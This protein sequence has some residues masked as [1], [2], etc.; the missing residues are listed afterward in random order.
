VPKRLRPS[1]E[2]AELIDRIR[3][4]VAERRQLEG[5]ASR[6]QIEANEVE[7]DCL[8]ARLATAVKRSLTGPVSSETPAGL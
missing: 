4:L 8:Q 6:E 1:H 2:I 3:Q 5:V 7:I